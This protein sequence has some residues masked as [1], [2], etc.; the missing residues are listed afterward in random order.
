MPSNARLAAQA[1]ESFKTWAA[2]RERAAQRADRAIAE[3]KRL[4]DEIHARCKLPRTLQETGKVSREQLDQ[5]AAGAADAA[6]EAA[7]ELGRDAPSGD[8]PACTYVGAVVLRSD[9]V[10]S[11]VGDSRIY[12]LAD[13]GSS[14]LLSVD[15]S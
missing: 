13:D 9:A 2:E 14:R 4:R 15:D 3:I 10:V 6:A 12:W 1:V 8:A 5:L 11:W 7:A